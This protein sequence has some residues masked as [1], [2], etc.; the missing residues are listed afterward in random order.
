MTKKIKKN[1]ATKKETPKKCG[2]CN[3]CCVGLRINSEDLKKDAG[4]PCGHLSKESGC[5]IYESRPQVCRGFKCWWLMID[6]M[7]HYFRPDR[8]GFIIIPENGS[9]LALTINPIKDHIQ[10][11]TSSDCLSFIAAC[12]TNNTK[13]FISVPTKPGHMN[14]KSL[15]TGV[16]TTHDLTSENEL[17]MKIFSVIA[18]AQ[19]HPTKLEVSLMN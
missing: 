18:S 10:T 6:S 12:I 9:N 15:L 5:S 2:K 16:V 4:V 13:L 7:P 3:L 11:L 8:C 1:A 14:A 17:R 19:E